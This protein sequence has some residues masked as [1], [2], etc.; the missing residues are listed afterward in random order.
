M[1]VGAVVSVADELEVDVDVDVSVDCDVSDAPD[2]VAPAE[3]SD[4]PAA[5]VVPEPLVVALPSV[6]WTTPVE[7]AA[8]SDVLAAFDR[9]PPRLEPSD[10]V[11]T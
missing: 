11:G 4:C 7:A 2:D 6:T 1:E 3:P 10:A 9:E 5:V 8:D